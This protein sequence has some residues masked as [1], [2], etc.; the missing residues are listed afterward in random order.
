M[1]HRLLAAVLLLAFVPTLQ[2]DDVEDRIKSIRA[3]YNATESAELTAKEIS[4]D[5]GSELAELTKYRN[6]EGEIVKLK[7]VTGSDHSAVT[8]YFYFKNGELYF[9]YQSQ[10]SWSFDP[11]G[12]ESA[13]ID[14]G[15][16]QRIYY[17]GDRVIRHLVK[18]VKS[19]D[20]DAISKLLAD[21]ENQSV[22][23]S[24]A[25]T[26]LQNAGYRLLKV[27]DRAQLEKYLYEE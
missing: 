6:R 22:N 19:R 20:P 8:D 18:E 4:F 7:Y 25:A 24:E 27:E 11:K 10:G 12:G 17:D 9:I 3:D 15:R 26:G 1:K 14:T 23:D 21:A 2:A 16:E 5:G 13:T